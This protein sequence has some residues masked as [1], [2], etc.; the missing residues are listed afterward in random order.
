VNVAPAP[1]PA[2]APATPTATVSSGN[3][4]TN[5]SIDRIDGEH[6]T[7]SYDLPLNYNN[8]ADIYRNIINTVNW[9]TNSVGNRNHASE[10][11]NDREEPE[12]SPDDNNN[13]NHADDD[14]VDID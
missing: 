14:I 9:M 13:N 6:V 8:N 4:P 3:V 12:G 11:S 1:A 10:H 7:F 5:F 2:P